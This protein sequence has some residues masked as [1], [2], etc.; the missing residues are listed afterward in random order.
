MTV[1]K[2]EREGVKKREY[3]GLEIWEIAKFP[4]K[5]TATVS[6]GQGNRLVFEGT[7]T[8]DRTHNSWK[9]GDEIQLV[10]YTREWPTHEKRA[11]HDGYNRI[12][13]PIP[14]VKAGTFFESALKKIWALPE[15]LVTDIE[16]PT[17]DRT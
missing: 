8:I 17:E 7:L 11:K 9:F 10:L 13:I 2:L 3:N 12:E 1:P 4:E 5:V 6:Y 14:L 15:Q 16:Q